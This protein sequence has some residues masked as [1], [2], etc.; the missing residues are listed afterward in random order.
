[1][2]ETTDLREAIEKLEASQAKVVS[3]PWN[4]YRGIFYGVGFFVGGTL[5]VGLIIYILTFLDTAPIVGYYISK[6]LGVLAT[7]K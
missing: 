7:T 2:S 6:I 4:F 3:L 1:M 5:L